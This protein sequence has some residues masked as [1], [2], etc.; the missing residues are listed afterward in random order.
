MFIQLRKLAL[1]GL[2]FVFACA[3]QSADKF[4]QRAT[5]EQQAA[6]EAA[7]AATNA[8]ATA[9][10]GD[11]ARRQ[12]FYQSVKGT[13]EGTLSTAAGKFTTRIKLIPS[14]PQYTTPTRIRTPE[15]ITVDLTNLSFNAQILH[16]AP[17]NNQSASG[18]VFQELRADLENGK[19]DLAKSD[20]PNVYSVNIVDPQA[21]PLENANDLAINSRSL[22]QKVLEGDV[23]LVNQLSVLMQPSNNATQF[24][25]TLKRVP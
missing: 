16:W 1:L 14:L 23:N 17:S 25:L 6:N 10:E 7:Q 13:F 8:R 15:E 11:L 24:V 2:L 12:R 5:V 20:C 9:M 3:K 19:I 18:C 21:G 22:S 4:Q